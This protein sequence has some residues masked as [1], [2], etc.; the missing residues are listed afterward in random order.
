MIIT[1]KNCFDVIGSFMG[2]FKDI[3]AGKRARAI[4][5]LLGAKNSRQFAMK[6]GITYATWNAIENGTSPISPSMPKRM[7]VPGIWNQS[8]RT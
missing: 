2:T 1:N 7:G 4:R 5:R 6:N 8:S 3:E